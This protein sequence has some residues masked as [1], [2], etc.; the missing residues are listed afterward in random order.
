[1]ISAVRK[2]KG[3]KGLVSCAVRLERQAGASPCWESLEGFLTRSGTALYVQRV[4]RCGHFR[5]S[6]CSLHSERPCYIPNTIQDML[7]ALKHLNLTNFYQKGMTL[8]EKTEAQ[9]D[10]VTCPRLRGGNVAEAR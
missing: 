7:C 10:M 8:P 5:I 4:G 1:M 3:S 6:L 2:K 9:R